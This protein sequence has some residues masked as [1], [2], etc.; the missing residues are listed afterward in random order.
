MSQF[1]LR[2]HGMVWDFRRM[3]VAYWPT[4]DTV[5]AA[6]FAVTEMGEVLDAFLRL[7]GGYARNRER[8]PDV[9]DELAD[10]AMMTLTAMGENA[11]LGEWDEWEE[12]ELGE[13]YADLDEIDALAMHVNDFYACAVMPHPSP[14]SLAGF[15]GL[16]IWR[17]SEYPGMD[18]EARL[19]QRL[20]RIFCKHHPDG[21]RLAKLEQERNGGVDW[22]C[23]TCAAKSVLYPGGLPDASNGVAYQN[24]MPGVYMSDGGLL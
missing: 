4:P 18:L 9:L 12:A 2:L 7:D 13:M 22:T 16:A 11:P 17:I 1:L 21:Q 24:E 10:T 23:P 6:R 14:I 15:G 5:D 3:M 20:D 8:S 19:R